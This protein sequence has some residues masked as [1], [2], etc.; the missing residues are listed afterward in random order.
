MLKGKSSMN[1]PIQKDERTKINIEKLREKQLMNLEFLKNLEDNIKKHSNQ[2][3]ESSVPKVKKLKQ[4]TLIEKYVLSRN[5]EDSNVNNSTK[6]SSLTN[7]LSENKLKNIS[8]ENRKQ[9]KHNCA[10]LKEY[11]NF[12]LNKIESEGTYVEDEVEQLKKC[13]VTYVN[14]NMNNRNRSNN[15]TNSSFSESKFS[16]SKNKSFSHFKVNK[17]DNV[18]NSNDSN[19]AINPKN[20]SNSIFSKT[21]S[22]SFLR[23]NGSCHIKLNNKNCKILLNQAQLKSSLNLSVNKTLNNRENISE[24]QLFTENFVDSRNNNT[25]YNKSLVS[26][27]YNQ[28]YDKLTKQKI[29]VYENF[30]LDFE[31]DIK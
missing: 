13:L 18:L 20:M 10:S 31:K 30:L 14:S 15:N 19:N 27:E 24:H 29:V 17:I 7:N 3:K 8:Q 4:Q 11:L 28:Q 22:K 6:I 21:N 23:K 5:I 1:I 12:K 9:S 25:T 26:E 16:N 2:I